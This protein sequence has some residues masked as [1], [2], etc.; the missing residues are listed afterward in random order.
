MGTL[1][2]RRKYVGIRS[3]G[4][5]Q[6]QTHQK[7]I[8][9]MTDQEAKRIALTAKHVTAKANLYDHAEDIAQDVLLNYL[10]GKGKHQAI[11]LSTID[12]IRKR[13]GSTRV[14]ESSR[15]QRH[16]L[17]Y[18]TELVDTPNR[19]RCESTDPFE[20]PLDLLNLKERVTVFM[21]YV[22][23]LQ[24]SEIAICLDVSEQRV[25]QIH[26]EA[27]EVLR[28][29]GGRRRALDVVR[30]T[31]ADSDRMKQNI[32]TAEAELKRRREGSCQEKAE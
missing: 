29:N 16:N 20:T 31:D 24:Q 8:W 1:L 11:A 23:G 27:I 3:L 14:S 13:F 19:G 10:E 5:A 32:I 22:W 26:R 6:S 28:G 15:S 12:M 17:A 25:Y 2:L 30:P 4:F 9:E 7:G 21:T 18:A